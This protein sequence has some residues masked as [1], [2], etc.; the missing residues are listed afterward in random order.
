MS[1][2]YHLR[3]FPAPSGAQKISVERTSLPTLITMSDL[4]TAAELSLLESQVVATLIPLIK[5]FIAAS[6][7][8]SPTMNVAKVETNANR[9]RET[10]IYTRNPA[11]HLGD[12]GTPPGY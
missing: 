9:V 1:S 2:P 6:S 8:A 3:F 11:A 5:D 12:H 4:S 10:L 7:I